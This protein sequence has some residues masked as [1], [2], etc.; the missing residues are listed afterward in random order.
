MTVNS[1]RDFI[2]PEPFEGQNYK[3]RY[4][5][6]SASLREELVLHMYVYMLVLTNCT[7]DAF[8]SSFLQYYYF[9]D[10]EVSLSDL[11]NPDSPSGDDSVPVHAIII[12]AS[13]FNFIDTQGVNT[14][15]QVG[16]GCL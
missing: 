13:T 4:A 7:S 8:L 16:N 5:R 12:D 6:P 11:G 15:L 1:T 9:Q 2:P 3:P 14:L 10:V